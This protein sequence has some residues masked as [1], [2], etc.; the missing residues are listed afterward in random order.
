M[1][2]LLHIGTEKTGT[3]L[4]QE[5]LYA[6]KSALSENR[7][8]LSQTIG[9]P[10]NRKF[11]AYFQDELDDFHARHQIR[12]NKDRERYFDGFLD[13]FAEEIAALSADHDVMVI[14]SE[15]FHSRVH[16]RDSVV[17]LAKFLN[18]HFDRV[19]VV[20]YFR[21]QSDV[22]KSLYSTALKSG[23]VVPVEKFIPRLSPANVYFNYL[24]MFEV[25]AD[26]FGDDN[27]QA[28]L[29]DRAGFQDRD[30][31]RDF[32]SRIDPQ[33]DPD[34]L[35][36]EI[37]TA[38]EKFSLLEA[39][40]TRLINRLQPDMQSNGEINPLREGLL[41]LLSSMSELKIGTIST[42]RQVEIYEMFDE[43]NRAFFKRFF[44]VEDNLFKP[45]ST[46]V[47]QD[48]WR[49]VRDFTALEAQLI[50][51]VF[52]MADSDVAPRLAS[53]DVDLLRDM[54]LKYEGDAT[55]SKDDAIALMRLARSS[56]PNGPTIVK[57]LREWT[58]S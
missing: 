10:N 19:D 29:Y 57:K 53:P 42:G 32:L 13:E 31:R 37:E 16:Q 34:L 18:A 8:A 21:E 11:S 24:T 49:E 48:D 9:F 54:A 5:W 17:A 52:A 35:D 47:D 15:H 43:S 51:L 50:E 12:T 28:V 20:C 7:I 27:L 22:H 45:P 14:S 41:A 2:C 4:L 6:N 25:W 26:V 36:Y 1:R 33:L 56:R 40:L 55:L 39:N 23:S 46:E 58:E 44:G 30:L 3:T 38:N